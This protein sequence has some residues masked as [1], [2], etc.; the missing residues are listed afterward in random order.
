VS[1]STGVT[2]TRRTVLQQQRQIP[3]SSAPDWLFKTLGGKGNCRDARDHGVSADATPQTVSCRP[4][5]STR[6]QGRQRDL[7]Q[8]VVGPGHSRSRT[9]SARAEGGRNRTS[10]IDST[11][12]D[13]IRR[14][15]SVRIRSA[16]DNDASSASSSTSRRRAS[17]GAAVTTPRR[18]GAASRS[19]WP[20]SRAS[21]SRTW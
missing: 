13:G 18:G 20:F 14:Q 2:S 16:L 1:R 21:R 11:V 19:A 5:P 17:A 8:L 7:H 4:W 3:R 9:S 10:G 12:V 15:R 6:N